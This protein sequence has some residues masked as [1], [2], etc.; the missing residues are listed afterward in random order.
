MSGGGTSGDVTLAVSVPLSLTGSVASPAAVIYATNTS[1]GYG[2]MGNNS[3]GNYGYLGSNYCGVYG[4][5]DTSGNYG[6]LGSSS[7][8]VHGYNSASG[9]YGYLGRSSYGVYG[10]SFSSSG[11]GVFGISSSGSGVIG[12]GSSYG[13]YGWGTGS[14]GSYGVYGYSNTGIG[15]Y[16]HSN[17]NYAGY[18][19]GGV[20]VTSSVYVAGNVSALSFTDRTPY[21]KDLVTAYQAVMSMERLPD[22]QYNENDKENQID[23]SK[24]SDFIRSQDGNRDLSAAVSALNEVVKDLIKK[25]EAQQ[26]LIEVQNAQIQQLVKT[27]QTNNNLKSLSRGEE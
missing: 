23:H 25:V 17:A 27:S 2:V 5:N 26:Q 18:F 21:P 3:T 12:Q 4:K 16:G 7:G 13:V 24:L 10:Q 8:G 19:D 15:V 11:T 6:Y 9:N 1:S 22:G 14:S 20:Y